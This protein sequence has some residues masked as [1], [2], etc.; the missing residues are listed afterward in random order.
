LSFILKGIESE[1]RL[2]LLIYIPVFH[3]Q[4]N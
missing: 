3:P 4:R 1:I 2:C